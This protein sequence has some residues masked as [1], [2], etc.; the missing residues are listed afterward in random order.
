VR[1]AFFETPYGEAQLEPVSTSPDVRHKLVWEALAMRMNKGLTV[2]VRK[3]LGDCASAAPTAVPACACRCA[4][5][6]VFHQTCLAPWGTGSTPHAHH[7]PHTTHAHHTPHTTHAHHTPHTT[8]AHHTPHTPHTHDNTHAQGRILNVTHNG[9]AV[10][11]AGYVA[12]LPH[13]QADAGQTR[14]I[15][16]LQEFTIHSLDHKRRVMRLSG[17][18]V[19]AVPQDMEE[20]YRRTL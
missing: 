18:K 14:R 19:R 4:R 3:P 13:G 17:T 8:H 11:V 10:A 15:G 1:L 2:Q 20:A 9:F 7:T 6:R 5:A 16:V 12:L